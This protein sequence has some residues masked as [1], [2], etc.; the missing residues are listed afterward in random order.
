MIVDEAILR[1]EDCS[2][3]MLGNP[4]DAGRTIE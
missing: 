3:E 4:T 1:S 2:P